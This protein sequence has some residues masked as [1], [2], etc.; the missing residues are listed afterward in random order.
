MKYKRAKAV[1]LETDAESYSKMCK[2]ILISACGPY[3]MPNTARAALLRDIYWFQ[4]FILGA[5]MPKPIAIV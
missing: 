1:W 5:H 3:C 4:L 2:I